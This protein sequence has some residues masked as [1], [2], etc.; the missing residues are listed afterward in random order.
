MTDHTNRRVA[1]RFWVQELTQFAYAKRGGYASPAPINRVVL[2]P[3]TGGKH[4][5]N[6]GWASATPSGRIEL[7][8]GNPETAAFFQQ[9]MDEGWDIAI[10]FEKRDDAELD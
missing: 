7:T 3:V 2:A 1:A 5:A 9:A 8:V 10:T 6:E 4:P